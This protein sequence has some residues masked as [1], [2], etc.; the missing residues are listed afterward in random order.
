MRECLD[1]IIAILVLLFAISAVGGGF[2]YVVIPY[3][4]RMLS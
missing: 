1:W 4:V 3:L 2:L